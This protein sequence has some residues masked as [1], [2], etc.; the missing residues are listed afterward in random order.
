MVPQRRPGRPKLVGE[1]RHDVAD[2]SHGDSLGDA[3][4]HLRFQRSDRER[5]ARGGLQ[6]GSDRGERLG[7]HAGRELTALGRGPEGGQE[8]EESQRDPEHQVTPSGETMTTLLTRPNPSSTCDTAV[9]SVRHSVP[10]TMNV[11]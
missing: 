5:V 1:A 6:Q 9:G 2:P 11:Y 8:R 10:S 7:V 4:E 3:L